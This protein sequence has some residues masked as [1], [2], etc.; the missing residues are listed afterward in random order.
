MVKNMNIKYKMLF[1]LVLFAL[2]FSGCNNSL[3]ND[4]DQNDNQDKNDEDEIT[5][6]EFNQCLAENGITIYG[7]KFCPACSA[8]VETLG[9]L[10]NAEPVYVEC[11]EEQERC[12]EE[13]KTNYIPEIHIN[14]NIYEGK[15]TLEALAKATNCTMP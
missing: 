4:T 8:L 2:F 7:S 1:V 15:R 6:L 10:E 3:N 11:S 13:T 14:G 5:M 12:N 9:G